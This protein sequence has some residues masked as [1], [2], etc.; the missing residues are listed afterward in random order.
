MAYKPERKRRKRFSR[1]PILSKN[2]T[3][4]RITGKFLI[5]Q[6]DRLHLLSTALQ[7]FFIAPFSVLDF[8]SVPHSSG[9]FIAML[10]SAISSLTDYY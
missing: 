5:Y 8:K 9:L 1:I 10:E 7:P 4:V 6:I 2:P 3:V